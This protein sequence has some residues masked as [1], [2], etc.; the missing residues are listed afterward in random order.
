MKKRILL[1][2]RYYSIEPLGILYLAGIV[3]QYEEWECK[4]VLINENDFE[5]LYETVRVWKPDVVG[6]QIW[7]GYHLLAFEACDRVRAMGVP[8]IIGGPHA[9]YFDSECAKHAEW[10]VKGGG[11]DFLKKILGGSVSQGVYFAR[12][13]REDSFPLPD[14]D[15]VY[16]EYPG[17]GASPIKS[18][19]ASVGCPM[20]CTYCYA[21]AFNKMHDGF[22]LLTRP[23]D[24]LVREAHAIMKR[25]PLKMIY[26]QDDIFGYD[27]NW[28]AE[29][30]R[31]WKTEVGVPFHSQIRLELTRHDKGDERLDLFRDAGCTGI[32]VAIE[33]GNSFLRDRVLFRHMPDELIVAGCQKILD[34]G[35]TLRTE[36]ILAVPFSDTATDLSTLDL[37]ARINPTMAWTSILVPYAGTDM[38]TIASNFGIYTRNNDDFS[39]TFFDRSVLR[40]VARGPHDIEQIVNSLDIPSNAQPKKQPLVNLR[41]MHLEGYT[42]R[43]VDTSGKSLGTIE[44]LSPEAN[45]RYCTDT[46]RLQRLFNWLAR[47]DGARE[48]GQKLVDVSDTDWSW[49]TVGIVTER[50]FLQTKSIQMLEAMRERLALEM[51]LSSSNEFPEIVAQN[52]YY[53]CAFPSGGQLAKQIVAAVESKD[54]RGEGFL[55]DIGTITRRHLFH[56]DLYRLDVATEPIAR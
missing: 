2:A 38:G 44:H 29:F 37:N 18:I 4:V 13:G 34:R 43:V 8:V 32:T 11:F 15:L 30:S 56:F 36:Q 20:F 48:L 17:L 14:R 54:G 45:Y 50:H 35:M 24:E 9:T 49:K 1:T 27:L 51:G 22:M 23:I 55:N 46:V 25:W 19:F 7:T 28:V 3:R 52:P 21:P 47:V 39:E 16:E 12:S 53:F 42:S 6:F 31:R 5:P 33:S 26:F 10:V 41:A 40:H